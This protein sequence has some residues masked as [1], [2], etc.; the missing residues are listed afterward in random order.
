MGIKTKSA[1][2]GGCIPA[3]AGVGSGYCRS[4]RAGEVDALLSGWS[5]A[6]GSLA[7]AV[8]LGRHLASDC[9]RRAGKGSAA[10]V[11]CT[12]VGCWCEARVGGAWCWGS[13]RAQKKLA[14]GAGEVELRGGEASWYR[15]RCAG[16]R[17]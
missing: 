9:E 15:G 2:V 3:L 6:G 10:A 16:R 11:A 12:V 1:G 8:E 7:E 17:W 13:R 4:E 5:C 14:V